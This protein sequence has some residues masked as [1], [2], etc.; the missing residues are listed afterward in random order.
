MKISDFDISSRFGEEKLVGFES[1]LVGWFFLGSKVGRSL[2]WVGV[3]SVLL[4]KGWELR[5]E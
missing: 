2:V 4:S 5:F 3:R 1:G